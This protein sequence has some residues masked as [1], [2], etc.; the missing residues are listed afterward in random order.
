MDILA[1]R[2]RVAEAVA[3]EQRSGALRALLAQQA[4]LAGAPQDTAAAQVGFLQQYVETAVADLEAAWAAADPHRRALLDWVA[5]LFLSVAPDAQ[6]GLAP[7]IERAYVV[8]ALLLS[9]AYRSTATTLGET[10]TW[11]RLLLGEPSAAALDQ[12]IAQAQ[13]ASPDELARARQAT[14]SSSTGA[15]PGAV[16]QGPHGAQFYGPELV[17]PPTGTVRHNVT[18]LA[19]PRASEGVHP[20][21]LLATRFDGWTVDVTSMAVDSQGRVVVAGSLRER[22]GRFQTL[23]SGRGFVV[24]Y[25]TD[26]NLDPRFG[27]AGCALFDGPPADGVHASRLTALSVDGDDGLAI[28]ATLDTT[29]PPWAKSAALLRL[30]NEG[31]LDRRFGTG[32]W[33]LAGVAF[34]TE[35]FGLA[36]QADGRMI[37][38]GSASHPDR[39]MVEGFALARYT[40][41]GAPDPTFG[42]SGRVDTS[43]LGGLERANAVVAHGE[44]IVA[45]G[46]VAP[47]GSRDGSFAVAKYDASG[48]LD[49]SFGMGGFAQATFAGAG[50]STDDEARAVAVAPDG[51][52]VAA[53]RSQAGGRSSLAVACFRPNGTLDD[54]FGVRGRAILSLADAAAPNQHEAA[55]LAIDSRGG[56]LI[57]GR[58]AAAPDRWD[59]LLVRMRP[60]GSLDE[61]F[62]DRGVIIADFFGMPDD[63]AR[64]MVVQQDAIVLAGTSGDGVAVLR[65]GRGIGTRPED[66]GVG[67]GDVVFA[68]LAASARGRAIALQ[69]DGRIVVA[70]EAQTDAGGLD[71]AVMRFGPDSAIDRSFGSA[72][73]AL[74]GFPDSDDGAVAVRVLDDG[75]IVVGGES[76]QTANGD[77]DL[78]IIRLTADG[79]RETRFQGQG[80]VL[81]RGFFG[82]RAPAVVTVDVD[83]SVIAAAPLTATRVQMVRFR[84]DGGLDTRFGA[85]GYVEMGSTFDVEPRAL[86]VQPDG[87]VVLA[88]TV[89]SGDGA[90]ADVGVARFNAD[91]A[92]DAAFGAGGWSV[93]DLE[94][95]DDIPHAV[96]VLPDGRI[97]IAGEAVFDEQDRRRSEAL[98]LCL[99]SDGT[100]DRGF[101]GW[102]GRLISE[103]PGAAFAITVDSRGDVVV[104]GFATVDG[105]DHLLAFR[106]RADGS[107][108]PALGAPGVVTKDAGG[109]AEYARA[110][111]AHPSGSIFIAGSSRA[112][113]QSRVVLARVADG[114]QPPAGS[115]R[116]G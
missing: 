54:S 66:P 101:N 28:A 113:R 22:G 37:V 85:D 44:A 63:G 73:V 5:T 100:P 45:A 53:G 67:G 96:A 32:G 12:V 64:A 30:T 36:L 72:G 62:G 17:P 48:V 61:T 39:A 112:D 57:A 11:V 95:S 29:T 88:A 15:S 52:I 93:I 83:G 104:A 8:H 26:G 16:G 115:E 7:L 107:L 34:D 87:K 49:A 50:F 51:R 25:A 82:G 110:V 94:E 18:D 24:R 84:N 9:L 99:G 105:R 55:A 103:V 56:I 89:R 4:V 33:A 42:S 65:V 80:V 41:E 27:Q 106:C 14:A 102:G 111:L 79:R 13:H 81:G 38:A 69:P 90:R 10:H 71:I 58:A 74:F 40:R 46:R 59:M 1:L 3:A 76:E 91:G 47:P 97:A 20:Q 43:F 86:A 108:D 78:L 77:R 68:P 2:R 116:H 109:D 92:I 60:D 23:Q 19:A 35:A 114:M 31:V 21:R 6:P 75:T 98:V 70:G